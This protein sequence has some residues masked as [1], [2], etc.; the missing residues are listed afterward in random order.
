M[1]SIHDATPLALVFSDEF[2]VEG[3]TFND[4]D[5]PRWTALRGKPSSNSQVNYYNPDLVGTRGGNLEL[6]MSTTSVTYPTYSEPASA[7]A[8]FQT[9]Y[10]ESWSKVCLTGGG[11]AEMRARLPA[12]STQ[13]G[14]WPA[15]WLFGN[16]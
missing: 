15:F 5:D 2:E 8:F 14:L 1:A 13:P 3:R 10:V 12:L 11:I 7:S 9:G 6:N 16:L 4:G